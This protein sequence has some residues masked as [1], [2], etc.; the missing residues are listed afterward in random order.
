M[1]LADAAL[2]IDNPVAF[3]AAVLGLAGLGG[4]AWAVFRSKSMQATVDT[5]EQALRIE[6]NERNVENERCRQDIAHLQG[7]VQVLVDGLGRTIAEAVLDHLDDSHP[8]PKG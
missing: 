8:P 3:A 4:A 1:I 2:T 6:R 7:Q 5:L